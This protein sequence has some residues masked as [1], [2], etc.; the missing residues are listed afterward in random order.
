MEDTISVAVRR[1]LTQF[2]G[3]LEHEDGWNRGQV[4]ISDVQDELSRFKVWVGNAGAQHSGRRSLDY[5]L[6]DASH[7]RIQ[8]LQLLGNMGDLLDGARDIL[9]G[10]QMPWDEEPPDSDSDSD[11]D[12]LSENNFSFDMPK[13]ELAQIVRNIGNIVSCLAR[14]AVAIRNP[15]P[16]DRFRESQAI[17]TS[18]AEPY[19]IQHVRN[20][21]PGIDS[22][23]SERLG[24]AICRRRQYFK[25]REAHHARLSEG[26][27]PDS[28]KT[29][30]TA[31]STVASSIPDASKKNQGFDVWAQGDDA[32][33]DT[34]LSRTSYANSTVN[35][36]GIRVPPLP[37]EA[38]KGPFECPYCYELIVARTRSAWK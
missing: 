34:G 16:H 30:A 21:F 17:D 22:N 8:V 31:K 24:K 10:K 12:E 26:L 33:S 37:K 19:D 25:Y 36:D 18:Y 23:I 6:R 11:D 4:Q 9:T 35:E 3:L 13:K 5:R 20:K 27:H 2:P 29:E 38:Q 32:E 1:C 7:L 14:L 28:S 15:A